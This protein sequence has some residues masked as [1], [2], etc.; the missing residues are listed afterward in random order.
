MYIANFKQPR[1]NWRK[2]QLGKLLVITAQLLVVTESFPVMKS[3][4]D[5]EIVFDAPSLLGVKMANRKV[6]KAD[7]MDAGAVLKWGLES[8]DADLLRAWDGKIGIVAEYQMFKGMKN[9]LALPKKVGAW[10]SDRLR[11]MTMVH[12]SL[13]RRATDQDD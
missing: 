7:G 8:A 5:S 3:L 12:L 1:N 11:M 10:L 2:E 13:G 6:I 4:P 9:D